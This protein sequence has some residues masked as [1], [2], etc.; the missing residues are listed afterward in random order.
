MATIIAGPI[1][2]KF[3]TM[4]TIFYTLLLLA[5]GGTAGCSAAVDAIFGGTVTVNPGSLKFTAVEGATTGVQ[6]VAFDCEDYDSTLE[7]DVTCGASITVETADK[8]DWLK[9]SKSSYDGNETV[10]VNTDT[11]GLAPGTYSGTITTEVDFCAVCDRAA[12]G[13]QLT[14][15][16]KNN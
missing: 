6:Q 11:T 13:V 15:T 16:P 8:K 7:R 14:I 9:V 4:K 1:E 3:A 10:D 12:V 2:R 5:L